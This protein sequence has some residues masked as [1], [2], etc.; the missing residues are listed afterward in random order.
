MK[1]NVKAP[2]LAL[3]YLLRPKLL[4]LGFF[5]GAFT[6][7]LASIIV[8]S[9]WNL[10]L[11]GATLW[12]A[13]PVMML[14]FLATWLIF[15]NLSLLIVED[16]IIDECQKNYWGEIRLAAKPTQASRLFREI[17]FSFF[18]ACLIVLLSIMSF[19]PGFA[20]IAFLLLAWINAYSFLS[21]LYSR[22][23]DSILQRLK[24]FSHDAIPNLA[25]GIMLS[26]LLFVPVLNV[27]LLGYAQILA[28]LVFFQR[29][30]KKSL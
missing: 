4:A 27:F 16:K 10:L 17:R 26:F 19:I 23:T 20:I 21:S 3:S 15:G 28:S 7:G 13:I 30:D 6:F 1:A 18:L 2:F 22:K 24:L 29:E 9:I 11:N 5:P 14:A 12:V 25:L 8:Y